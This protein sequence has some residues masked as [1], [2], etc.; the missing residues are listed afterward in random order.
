MSSTKLPLFSE[1]ST[2]A[3]T[4]S[5]RT[6]DLISLLLPLFLLCA[7]PAAQIASVTLDL[8]DTRIAL[9]GKSA[10]T[11]FA[12]PGKRH[13]DRSKTLLLNQSSSKLLLGSL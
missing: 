2:A 11:E 7:L 5:T 3:P 6:D 12:H 1:Q 9:G 8:H 13:G 4:P 10:N